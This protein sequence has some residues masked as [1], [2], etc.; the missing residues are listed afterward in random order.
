MQKNFDT[1]ILN[2]AYLYEKNRIPKFNR[3]NIINILS[4]L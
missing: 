3:Y 1:R 4:Y 2:P